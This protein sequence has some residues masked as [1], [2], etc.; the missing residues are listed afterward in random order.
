MFFAAPLAVIAILSSVSARPIHYRRALDFGKCGSPEIQFANGLDGRNEPSFQAINQKDFN[1]GSALNIGVITSFNCQRLADSCKAPQAT[2]D[3]CAKGQADAAATGGKDAKASDAF[4]AALGV[5]G[6]AKAADP[7]KAANPPANPPAQ[8]TNCPA[9]TTVTVTAAAPQKTE[10]PPAANP[11]ANPPAKTDDAPPA[12]NNGSFDFGKCAP[13]TIEF[14]PGFEG[15][16]A[17]E[18][19]FKPVNKQ[20]FAQ[21]SA[22]NGNIVTNAVCNILKDRCAAPQA[23]LDACAKGKADFATKTAGAAADS[24]NAAFD[25]KTDF[26]NLVIAPSLG[27]CSNPT[28]VFDVGF[29]GRTEKSFQPANKAD[30]NHSSALNG[31][32]IT[33]AICDTFTNSCDANAPAIA[34]CKAA[35]AAANG[36]TGQEFADTFNAAVVKDLK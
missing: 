20:D 30:F 27:K 18:N 23:T 35:Q 11:P 32:I 10:A 14:G 5:G 19:S 33:Q 6:G 22:L 36:K 26:A 16:K 34:N 4:N 3:A 29:D 7:P 9:Q 21:G 2:L 8:A 1:H 12:V 25:I 28:I 17:S 13:P 31:N 15:R 24:F